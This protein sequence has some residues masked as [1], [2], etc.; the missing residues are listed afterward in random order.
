MRNA[1]WR[2]FLRDA[3]RTSQAE[4]PSLFNLPGWSSTPSFADGPCLLASASL[5][6]RSGFRSDQGTPFLRLVRWRFAR[7]VIQEPGHYNA[8]LLRHRRIGISR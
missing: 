2:S 3:S 7:D 5:D 4:A 6:A 8:P 1:Q